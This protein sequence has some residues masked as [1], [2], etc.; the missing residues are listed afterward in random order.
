[1][2]LK[3]AFLKL[4]ERFP[5]HIKIFRVY[6]DDFTE[7][8]INELPEI[9]FIITDDSRRVDENTLFFSTYYSKKFLNDAI[10]KKPVGLFLSKKEFQDILHQPYEGYC[11]VGKKKPDFYLGYLSSIYYDDPSKNM[12]IV[13]ITGTNGK[14]TTSFMIYHLWKK[15]T[16]SMC[17][18]RYIRCL[19]LEW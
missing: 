8:Q 4:E 13:A 9:G 1:M 11:I 6:K 14:T 18:N 5:S 12:Y 3:K 16:N 19:L 17:S 2:N 10:S 15:K 7:I